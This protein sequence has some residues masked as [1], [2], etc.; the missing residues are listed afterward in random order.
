[1]KHLVMTAAAAA[2][3]L[4]SGAALAQDAQKLLK[5][6]AC[7]SCHVA[8]K[9]LIGPPYKEVAAKYKTQKD[10]EGYLVAGLSYATKFNLGA[11]VELPYTI[12]WF[13]VP[14]SAPFGQTPKL[15]ILHP[16]LLR[17]AATAWKAA[18]ASLG[19]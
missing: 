11:T 10:A 15:G 2:L 9:K 13:A 8:D 12:A 7:L 6:K 1:M 5:E 14:P 17:R 18:G 16:K 4:A 3:A 19:D